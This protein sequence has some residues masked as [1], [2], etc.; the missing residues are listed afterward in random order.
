MKQIQKIFSANFVHICIERFDHQLFPRKKN[1]PLILDKIA[2]FSAIYL[3][4]VR[5]KNYEEKR[6]KSAS[7]L[8]PCFDFVALWTPTISLVAGTWTPKFVQF[9]CAHGCER[10]FSPQFAI[11]KWKISFVKSKWKTVI[12]QNEFRQIVWV[13]QIEFGESEFFGIGRLP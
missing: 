3:A 2:K 4:N 8:V 7:P 12:I 10:G 6:G 13:A 11:L 1:I 5:R 9:S